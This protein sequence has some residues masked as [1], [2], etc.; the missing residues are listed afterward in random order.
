MTESTGDL[1]AHDG[2]RPASDVPS[3]ALLLTQ[4]ERSLR[5]QLDPPLAEA[6]LTFEH[7][8]IMTVLLARPGAR[9]SAIADEAVLPAATLT[10]HMDHLVERAMVVRRIDPGDKRR[11]V[12]A[13]SPMG[14]ELALRLRAVERVVEAAIAQGLGSARFAT[15]GHELSLIPHLFD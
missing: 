13:L 12:A 9:M 1:A 14:E 2:L 5:R 15:L 3:L 4:A 6:G 7:W 11:V 8:R 10:R